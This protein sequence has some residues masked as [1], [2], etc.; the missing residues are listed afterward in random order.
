MSE[1]LAHHRRMLEQESAIA[2]EVI[3]ARGY[4]TVEKKTELEALGF[5][6][7]LQYVPSLVIPNHGVVKGE[8][9]WFMHRP[10]E[11]PVKQGKVR[12]YL[13]A[14]GQRMALDVNPCVHA[15]LGDP[16][17]S[18]FITE[19]AKKVDALITAGAKGVVGLGG[20]WTWRA[21]N[22][23][24]GKT[25]LP[26]WEYVHLAERQVFIVFDSDVSL[27]R[28]VGQAME[29][30]GAVL[31]RRGA[32]VGYV[33][34]PAA[35]DGSKVGADDF[36]AAGHSLAD[37]VALASSEV[38][39][40]ERPRKRPVPQV[41]PVEL[42]DA[43][44]VYQEWLHLPNPEPLYVV[45]GAIAANRLSGE[46][47]WLLVVDVSGSG[48]TEIIRAC[49]D[50][51]ECVHISS[52]TEAGLLSGTSRSETAEDATGGVLPQIGRQGVIVAKDFTSVLAMEKESRGKVLA[53]LREVYDGDYT[54]QLGTDGGRELRWRGKA[55][56]VGGVTPDIDQQYLVM[57]RMG[58]RYLLYR[59]PARDSDHVRKAISKAQA[60]AAH[61]EELRDALSQAALG[62][63]A[64]R[65]K[66]P[67]DP[68]EAE[69]E[70]LF[71]LALLAARGRAGV[72]TDFRREPEVG[73]A[74]ELPTRLTMELTGL[75]A[76]MDSIGVARED[77]LRAVGNTAL[78][79]I[80]AD[81]R[82]VLDLLNTASSQVKTR[83]V[84]VELGS[85]TR[86]A[87]RVLL[88]LLLHGLVER[89]SKGKGHADEWDLRGWARTALARATSIPTPDRDSARTPPPATVDVDSEP[90]SGFRPH[91]LFGTVRAESGSRCKN[92]DDGTESRSESGIE[93]FRRRLEEARRRGA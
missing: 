68:S 86:T 12:K 79:C 81:R 45:W 58:Q 70:W 51:S 18:L 69:R 29:R 64:G 6:R 10:D 35:K 9:P 47:V 22:D 61:V 30:L 93:E 21:T 19:G 55:G 34:L 56:F 52:L 39:R 80:P 17:A 84:A 41:E 23:H 89:D 40:P 14:Q 38:R 26:D 63:F 76:G 16:E 5:G 2:P 72:V 44:D 59:P 20:V 91:T 92:D 74:P 36:L 73:I 24:G 85:S 11:P 15:G 88:E 31:S 1:L 67:R 49:G 71:D 60:N 82:R 62:V 83:A 90:T 57:A 25:M 65:S 43:V 75:L 8:P 48:K 66:L 7:A 54:R 32:N 13:I 3:A 33:Y 28:E 77:A 53:A 42:G 37:I 4:F 46:P 78:G 27:K 87:R 50:L